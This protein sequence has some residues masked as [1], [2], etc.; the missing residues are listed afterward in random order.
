M[1]SPRYLQD[2]GAC[3]PF[4]WGKV[5]TSGA[6]VYQVCWNLETLHHFS[7]SPV[8]AKPDKFLLALALAYTRQ[9][10]AF[11]KFQ[12]TP[13]WVLK[14]LSGPS[15]KAS[16]ENENKE[17]RDKNLLKRL[18][19]M[20][21]GCLQLTLWIE[22]AMR[23][24]LVRLR[25]Q[26]PDFWEAIGA[27]LTDYKLGAVA[28]RLQT[29]YHRRS[30]SDWTGRATRLLGDL[31]LCC[32]GF[33]RWEELQEPFQQDLLRY[34]GMSLRKEAVAAGPG[35]VDDWWVASV[36]Y[37]PMHTDLQG[38]FVWLLGSRSR[39]YAQLADFSW[40][41]SPWEESY[42]VHT[43]RPG[44]MHFHP[45][46]YPQRAVCVSQENTRAVPASFPQGMPDWKSFLSAYREALKQ[47]MLLEEFPGI[48]ENLSLSSSETLFLEDA[49]G[50]TLPVDGDYPDKWE[51][52]ARGE[53]GPMRI[54]GTWNGQAF[55]PKSFG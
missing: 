38:R 28:G 36:E 55:F 22:D 23:L 42:E 1:A 13:D 15:R 21:E 2:S 41:G 29:L 35:L 47:Q 18:A 9:P 31:V 33:S 7:N 27:R 40:R 49:K 10:G 16:R 20:Q 3:L 44:T 24:G 52:I 46:A 17:I 39:Q 12:D 4:I 32:E 53:S 19:Q 50:M 30:E 45:S 11:P 54:F 51:L 37:R 6:M 26:G 8:R 43:Q 48:V 14:S 34:G 25:E 5:S